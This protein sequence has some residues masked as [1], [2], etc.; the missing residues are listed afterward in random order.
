M[1]KSKLKA[2]IASAA[3]A[4]PSGTTAAR[5]ASA[6]RVPPRGCKGRSPLHKKKIPPRREGGRGDGGKKQAKGRDSQCRRGW[7]QQSKL[8]AGRASAAGGKPPFRHH[9]GKVC[10]C[11]PGSVRVPGQAPRPSGY[12]IG[13]VSPQP[14]RKHPAGNNRRGCSK[15][16]SAELSLD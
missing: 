9:S 13:S 11:R 6:A 15:N 2:G 16:R 10:K 8:K 1:G 12:R 4:S 14:K 7:G 5:S 3:G